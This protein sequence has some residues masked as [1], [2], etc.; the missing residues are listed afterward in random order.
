QLGSAL[1]D[2][3]REK[4]LLVLNNAQ[5]LPSEYLKW[6]LNGV[7]GPPGRRVGVVLEGAFDPDRLLETAFPNGIPFMPLIE[8]VEPVSPWRAITEAEE[9]CASRPVH[10]EP[11]IIPWLVDAAGDDL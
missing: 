2:S 10:T 7:V 6:L 1:A 4:M 9:V 5:R 3:A 11:I 8:Y